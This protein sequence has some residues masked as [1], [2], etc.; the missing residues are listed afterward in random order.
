M[1]LLIE[2]QYL[3]LFAHDF[4]CLIKILKKIQVAP[5]KVNKVNILADDVM[6][7]ER[8]K[9]STEAAHKFRQFQEEKLQFSEL[10]SS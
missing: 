6:V 2:Q 5:L 9:K 8:R 10:T 7:V 4:I 3:E 1:R